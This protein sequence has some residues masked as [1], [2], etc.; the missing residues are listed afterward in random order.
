MLV[1][2]DE[3][4]ANVAKLLRNH[5]MRERNRYEYVGY[6]YRM[7][8]LVAALGLG[9][10]KLLSQRQRLRRQRAASY[11]LV[12]PDGIRPAVRDGVTHAWHQYTIQLPHRNHRDRFSS[13]CDKAG[14]DTAVFYDPGLHE[15]PHLRGR[16]K[17]AGSLRVASEASGRVLSLPVHPGV[18]N[19]DVARITQVLSGAYDRAS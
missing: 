9:Q 6:N 3:N 18:T 19:E 13:A 17:T 11:S 8:E 4:I 5:G 14:I 15:S 1:T 16:V 2:S 7:T 12:L 10:L